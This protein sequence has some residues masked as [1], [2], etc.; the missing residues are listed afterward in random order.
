MA[1]DADSIKPLE[2]TPIATSPLSDFLVSRL[3]PEFLE[4]YRTHYVGKPRVHEMPPITF[5][6]YD[7]RRLPRQLYLLLRVVAF[8]GCRQLRSWGTPKGE[9]WQGGR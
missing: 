3:C 6:R 8:Q 9:S 2:L 5:R 7:V 1:F 4:L